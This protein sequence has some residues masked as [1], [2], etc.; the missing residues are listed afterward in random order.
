MAGRCSVWLCGGGGVGLRGRSGRRS[1]RRGAAV[2][3]GEAVAA[4]LGCDAWQPATQTHQEPSPR[5]LS[6]VLGR[7]VLRM[8]RR[9]RNWPKRFVINELYRFLQKNFRS[10]VSTLKLDHAK[11]LQIGMIYEI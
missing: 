5:Y 2:R 4:R 10:N 1:G 11:T 6:Y 7:T 8:R 3:S 9:A